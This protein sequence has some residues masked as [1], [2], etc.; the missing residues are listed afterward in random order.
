MLTLVT[1]AHPPHLYRKVCRT[2]ALAC[3]LVAWA[4]LGGC[5]SSQSRDASSATSQPAASR[6]ADVKPSGDADACV[7]TQPIR[8]RAPESTSGG[9]PSPGSYSWFVNAD[10]SI[11]MFDQ[12]RV[13]GQRAK[14]AWF[15]P[16]RTRL[17][18]TGRRLDAA[19]PPL[20]V[21]VNASGDAYRN[22]FQPSNLTFPTE[23]CWELTA[24]AGGS[25]ARFVMK[26]EPAD[27]S[28]SAAR[29]PTK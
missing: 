10:R 4:L 9:P 26:V 24:Q 8:S 21:E 29:A 3:L 7:L 27:G 19:A 16:A 6:S 11:W 1:S 22:R 2:C 20:L 5:E 15:R 28:S 12:P 13:A 25:E 18:I 14:T 17:E 23:G